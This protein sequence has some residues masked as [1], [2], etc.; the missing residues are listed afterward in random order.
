MTIWFVYMYLLNLWNNVVNGTSCFI[1]WHFTGENV[2]FI[3]HTVPITIL[4]SEG[5]FLCFTVQMLFWKVHIKNCLGFNSLV[6]KALLWFS[7]EVGL[8][9][10]L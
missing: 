4:C 6:H 10:M 9:K 8:E 1:V 2:P 5:K 7:C 3:G